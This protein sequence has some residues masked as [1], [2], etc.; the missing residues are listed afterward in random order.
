MEIVPFDDAAA[1]ANVIFV[2]LHLAP[3]NTYRIDAVQTFSNCS[4]VWRFLRITVFR[5]GK[6]AP[7][8]SIQFDVAGHGFPRKTDLSET[9]ALKNDLPRGANEN[10][11]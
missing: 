8:T 1:C 7:Q 4:D 3:F 11:R 6:G 9:R 10:A 2:G 5:I